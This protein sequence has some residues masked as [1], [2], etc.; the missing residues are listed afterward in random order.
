MGFGQPRLPM[1]N[2]WPVLYNAVLKLCL[3]SG[4][5]C[6]SWNFIDEAK[7]TKQEL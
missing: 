5:P 2:G 3:H 4:A 7:H 1:L 6:R